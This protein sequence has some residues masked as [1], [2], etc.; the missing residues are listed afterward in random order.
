MDEGGG[1]VVDVPIRTVIFIL[2][3][4]RIASVILLQAP[5]YTR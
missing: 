2:E 1:G 5:S 4:V 3:A